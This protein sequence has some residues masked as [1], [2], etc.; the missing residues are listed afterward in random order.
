MSAAEKATVLERVGASSMP[1]R[2]VLRELGVPKSTYYRWRSRSGSSDAATSPMRRRVPWNRLTTD[3]EHTILRVARASPE[4]SSRQV[5]AWITDHED[6]SVSEATVYRVL[7]RED[8][9]R[10]LETVDPAGK[11]CRTSA[12]MGHI[13]YERDWVGASCSLRVWLRSL[14]C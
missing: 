3:E 11:E 7:R 5:A 1:A 9:V 14:R 12:R 13:R 10:R 6:V 2:Q 4:W 8:L